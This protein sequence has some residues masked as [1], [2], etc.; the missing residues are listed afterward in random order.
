MTLTPASTG[1]SMTLRFSGSGE[2]RLFQN[3]G[4][5]KTVGFDTSPGPDEGAL[6]IRYDEPL[7]GF[8]VQTATFPSAGDLVLTD[9]CCDGF[10]YRYVR[11]P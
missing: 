8:E 5:V 10:V 1:E 2:A 9:P 7:M 3:G 6:E 11:A 4:L